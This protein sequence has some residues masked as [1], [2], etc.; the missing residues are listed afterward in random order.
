[1][2]KEKSDKI[3]L[4]AAENEANNELLASFSTISSG[5]LAIF[6][7]YSSRAKGL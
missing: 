7:R 6:T 1:V 3:S 5:I 2:A 4:I